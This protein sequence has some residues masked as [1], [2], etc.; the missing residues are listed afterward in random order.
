MKLQKSFW[1]IV[2][3]AASVLL[4]YLW[5]LN[6]KKVSF[7]VSTQDAKYAQL[8]SQIANLQTQINHI[9]QEPILEIA[10]YI[11][12]ANMY[13]VV[14][15][16]VNTSLRLMQWTQQQMMTHAP[17]GLQQALMAD[18]AMLQTA[19]VPNLTQITQNLSQVAEQVLTL[20]LRQ[21]LSQKMVENNGATSEKTWRQA[22]HHAWL[23]VKN[24]IR[25]QPRNTSMDYV[26]FDETILRETVRVELRRASIAATL[27]DVDLYQA[28]LEQ[29]ILALQQFFENSDINVQTATALLQHLTQQSI[30]PEIP[31]ANHAQM[32]LHHNTN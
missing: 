14:L 29:A 12:R 19:K 22:L 7:F 18:I 6:D 5:V 15:K 26:L 10:Y 32:W 28:S 2:L 11:N 25:V 4:G 24:L 27:G 9:N 31:E 8:H 21:R 23:E 30:V 17:M 13:L 16:D 1:I 3:I 20:P